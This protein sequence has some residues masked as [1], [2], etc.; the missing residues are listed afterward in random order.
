MTLNSSNGILLRREVDDFL[1]GAVFGS[2]ITRRDSEYLFNDFFRKP[3]HG[4]PLS[5]RNCA[6]EIRDTRDS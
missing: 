4:F 6:L 2:V 3:H 1:S 5:L